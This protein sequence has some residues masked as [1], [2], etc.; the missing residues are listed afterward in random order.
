MPRGSSFT[1]FEKTN[2]KKFHKNGDSLREIAKKIKRSHTVVK[3]FLDN[4]SIYATKKR[5]G[6]KT[7]VSPRLKRNILK[8][9]SNT[10]MSSAKI[11]DELCLKMSRSTIDR[12]R[13]SATY[14]KYTKK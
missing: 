10:S 4:P 14:L 7:I 9:S 11:I 13:R 2:I 5:S 1:Q 8:K 6:R 12:V 3:N